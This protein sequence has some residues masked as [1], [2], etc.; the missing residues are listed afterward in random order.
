VV[1]PVLV[2]NAMAA[3]IRTM[4]T[5]ATMVVALFPVLGSL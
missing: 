2:A 1:G 5:R 3:A 4:T